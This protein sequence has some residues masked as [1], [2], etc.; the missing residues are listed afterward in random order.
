[1]ASLN[2]T[3]IFQDSKLSESG[4]LEWQ[5]TITDGYAVKRIDNKL[6]RIH[7]IVATYLIPNPDNLEMV[8]HSCDNRACINPRHLRWGTQ[9]DNMRDLSLRKRGGK[10]YGDNHP[11]TKLSEDDKNKIRSEKDS[12]VT[13]TYLAKK[14]NVHQSTISLIVNNKKRSRLK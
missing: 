9:K 13:Q 14:Y 12:G 2:L 8:L 3:K 5:K 6:Q 10:T 1:M 11:G 4:C 7:R